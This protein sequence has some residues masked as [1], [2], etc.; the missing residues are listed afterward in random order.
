MQPEFIVG[1]EMRILS[2]KATGRNDN[3]SVN[4]YGNGRMN[5]VIGLDRASFRFEEEEGHHYLYISPNNS[6]DGALKIVPP[7]SRGQNAWMCTLTGEIA[8]QIA[9]NGY[10]YKKYT[11]LFQI[12]E[13]DETPFGVFR[14]VRLDLDISDDDVLPEIEEE[15]ENEDNKSQLD[16]IE[17]MCAD[18]VEDI[19][20]LRRW[21]NAE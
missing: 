13:E 17:K 18:M 7:P 12:A 5:K 9:E 14:T 11:G 19:K 2:F 10:L 4:V 6:D 1:K 16:R 20:V 15:V 8:D 21:L 3:P